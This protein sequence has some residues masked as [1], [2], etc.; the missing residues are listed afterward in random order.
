[1][2]LKYNILILGLINDVI[3]LY[4][5]NFDY[6]LEP[7]SCKADINSYLFSFENQFYSFRNFDPY[8]SCQLSLN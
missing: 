6:T 5:Q 7:H 1:L 3:Q 8:N 2:K 4:E